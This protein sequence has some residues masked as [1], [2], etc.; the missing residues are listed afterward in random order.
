M[1]TVWDYISFSFVQVMQ[2]HGM[3]ALRDNPEMMGTSVGML[4]RAAAMLRLLVKVPQAYRVYAKFQQRLLQFTMSQLV[5]RLIMHRSIRIMLYF[6]SSM[7]LNLSMKYLYLFSK[8]YLLF[9]KDCCFFLII[10]S[11]N[12]C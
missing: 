2:T 7:T 3:P 11:L 4:R 12:F 1:L 8:F 10:L 9:S 5:S 6:F